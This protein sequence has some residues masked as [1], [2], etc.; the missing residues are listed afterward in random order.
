[1]KNINKVKK[2]L[3]KHRTDKYGDLNLS[4]LDF[5]DFNGDVRFNDIKVK[6]N[7]FQRSQIV[8]GHLFQGFQIVGGTLKQNWQNVGDD[9]HQNYQKVGGNLYQTNNKTMEE[10]VIYDEIKQL[11]EKLDLIIKDLEELKQWKN[12]E[13]K[14]NENFNELL[15]N[16]GK[17]E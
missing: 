2:Y 6:N 12:R 4:G 11:K 9:L 15:K 1:M 3:I 7:L 5:S 17:E 16:I 10:K 14:F 13:M 8:G